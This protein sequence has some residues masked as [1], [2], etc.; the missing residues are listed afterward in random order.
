MPATGADNEGGDL[1]VELVELAVGDSVVDG[2]E[3]GVS[4]VDVGGD[5]V[6]PGGSIGI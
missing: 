6:V 1:A 3:V 2:P 4:R 5:V